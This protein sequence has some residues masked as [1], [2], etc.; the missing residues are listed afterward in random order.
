MVRERRLLSGDLKSALEGE[1]SQL[2]AEEAAGATRA[3][4][5][6]DPTLQ[7]VPAAPP[8]AKRD[9]QATLDALSAIPPEVV[10]PILILA[11]DL[12]VKRGVQAATNKETAQRFALTADERQQLGEVWLPVVKLYMPQLAIHPLIAAGGYTALVYALKA[13]PEGG[14]DAVLGGFGG[15]A[16]PPAVSPDVPSTTAELVNPPVQNADAVLDMVRQQ[17]D[18]LKRQKEELARKGTAA[19]A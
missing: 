9:A 4:R 14:L 7:P 18:E 5:A 15:A 13:L 16:A 12:L 3:E 2:Q 1:V 17:A 8:A 11:L 10:T 19:T 6:A